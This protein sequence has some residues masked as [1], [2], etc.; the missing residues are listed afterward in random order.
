MMM[1]PKSISPRPEIGAKRRGGGGCVCFWLFRGGGGQWLD[2]DDKK[3]RKTT[4]NIPAITSG[5]WKFSSG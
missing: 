1:I 3:H 5:P 4:V 2:D